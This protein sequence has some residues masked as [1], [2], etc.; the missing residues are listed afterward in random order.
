MEAGKSAKQPAAWSRYFRRL[1]RPFLSASEKKRLSEV[2]GEQERRTTGEIH[3]HIVE[4]AGSADIALLAQEKFLELGLQKT[5]SR[6]AVLLLISHLDHRFAILGDE[7][8]HVK[9][10]QKLWEHAKEVLLSHFKERRYAQGIEA[11]VRE[12]GQELARHFPKD[13]GDGL[14]QIPNDVTES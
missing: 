9:A 5:D 8:I 7:G 13:A 10:G 2:I 1:S 11:C 4:R 14:N 12:I 6:N 3:V